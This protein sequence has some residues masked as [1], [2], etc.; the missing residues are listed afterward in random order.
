MTWLVTGGAGFIGA[1]VVHALRAAAE[2]VVVLDDGSTGVPARIAGVPLVDGSVHDTALVTR[3][4]REY[5]V[6]GVVHLA[7]KK[8]PGESVER[9]AYYY[10]ENVGGLA[11]LLE[12]MGEAGV[13]SL[14]FSS[15]ASVYGN[16]GVDVVHED[17]DC[18]PESPYGETK[19]AGEWL[20]AAAGRTIPSRHISLRYFNVAGAGAP[21]LADTGAFNL[22]PMVFER[23]DAGERPVIFGTDYPTAD[24]TCIRDYVHVLDLAD[25]H[26]AAARYLRGATGPVAHTL[27]VGTGAGVS[28]AEMV[29]TILEVTGYADRQPTLTGRRPGDPVVSIASAERIRRTLG[30]AARHDVKE[31]VAS[32]WVGWR[33]YRDRSS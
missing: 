16:P 27:N 25:A 29:A 4:L 28:V 7:A 31:M 21:E 2:S 3:T 11:S 6:T 5:A 24:G 20:V 17:L 9:P 32:A 8:Q 26:V 12:A 1:H 19:L 22:I 15:S 14:V 23:L 18:R 30:W 10:R 13:E 33:R